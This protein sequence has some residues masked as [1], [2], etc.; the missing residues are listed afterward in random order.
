MA[1]F[2]LLRTPSCCRH[3]HG[4]QLLS[5]LHDL[6]LTGCPSEHRIVRALLRRAARPVMSD[7]LDWLLEGRL[8]KGNS[9]FF[10]QRQEAVAE[11]DCWAQEFL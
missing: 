4:G 1:P 11:A 6:S 8:R 7:S 10:V 5:T 9:S 3:L 2:P